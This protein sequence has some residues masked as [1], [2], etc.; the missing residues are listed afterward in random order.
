MLP[1][2]RQ[3]GL[4]FL[5]SM[6]VVPLANAQPAKVFDNFTL[7]YENDFLA[8]TDRDYTSGLKLTWSTPFTE[9]SATAGWPAWVS[10]LLER[11]PLVNHPDQQRALSLSF[12]QE[13]YT[14]EDIRTDLLVEDD[15]PYA[16]RTYFA[17]G[18]H[19]KQGLR[20]S[21]WELNVG[22]LGPA[23]LA[24]Q[25]QKLVHDLNGAYDPQGW[26]HQLEN[27]LTLDAVFETQW[28]LRPGGT[29]S[30]FFADFIP[31]LGARVG[32]VATYFNA[33]GEFRFGWGPA[34]EFGVCPIRAG[35]DVRSAFMHSDSD[36]AARSKVGAHV[37]F[38]ADG[39][40]VLRDIYLDG[41]TFRDSHS[42]DKKP[43]VADLIAGLSGHYGGFKITYSYILRSKQFETQDHAQE[44]SSLSLSWMF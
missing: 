15:R 28:R 14:P 3:L 12:G 9:D 29:P 35:C 22:I 41:N 40:A 6:C 18:F 10:P 4:I 11:L 30:V 24:E 8:G 39:R 27:E 36:K 2:I 25:A 42:V 1:V 31:H 44:F 16:G 26:E 33:G 37:F 5:L 7:Y 38:A 34:E 43:F 13:I 23:S 20:K 32:N 19:A 21:V 17:V